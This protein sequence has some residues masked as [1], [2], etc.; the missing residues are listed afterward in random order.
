MFLN[1]VLATPKAVCG[2]QFPGGGGAGS[3]EHT[4]GFLVSS[5]GP[6]PSQAAV[7]DGASCTRLGCQSQTPAM[8]GSWLSH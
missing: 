5:A 1:E 8:V 2:R 6:V 4:A 3:P 7:P